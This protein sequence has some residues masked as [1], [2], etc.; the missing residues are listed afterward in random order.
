MHPL[1]SSPADQ[2]LTGWLRDRLEGRRAD[3]IVFDYVGFPPEVLESVRAEF[4]VPV[5]DLGH[6]A[7]A[8]LNRILD[9]PEDWLFDR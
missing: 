9:P 1:G 3:A 8:A 6:V 5:L 2:A 7:I 4:D